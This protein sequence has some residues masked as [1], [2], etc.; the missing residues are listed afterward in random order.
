MIIF[1]ISFLLMLLSGSIFILGFHAIT[2]GKELI[3]PDGSIEIEKEIF[4]EWQLFW[5]QIVKYN[6]VFYS[7]EQLTYKLKILEQLKPAYMN[8]IS[9]TQD[10]KMRKAFIFN[11]PPTAAEVRD[12]EFS[13]NVKTV[14]KNEVLFLYDE[15]PVYRFSEWVRK[16][17]NCHICLSSIGGTICYW[18]INYF[19]KDLFALAV[20]ST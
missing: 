1:L 15:F 20:H 14:Q 10:P 17:T 8:E 9:L 19:Y 5:E 12:I 2:R 18:T 11:I 6:K 13:L 16:I 7:G 3:L 4:G